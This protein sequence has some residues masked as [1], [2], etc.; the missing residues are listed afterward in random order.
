VAKYRITDPA[1]G[2]TI[3]VSGTAP[4]TQE[5]AAAIFAARKPNLT[6]D[7]LSTPAPVAPPTAMDSLKGAGEAA[8]SLGT[9]LA[10][11]VIS[12]PVA[13]IAALGDIGLRKMAG[14]TEPSPSGEIV[15]KYTLDGYQPKTPEGERMLDFATAPIRALDRGT[16]AA[17]NA[18][19][20]AIIQNVQ[21]VEAERGESLPTGIS[22]IPATAV[23][24][25][26]DLLATAVGMRFPRSPLE[27]LADVRRVERQASDLGVDLTAK[28]DVQTSQLQ[29]AADQMEPASTPSE[30]LEAL[31][32]AIRR[33]RSN[34]S[35]RIGGI[36]DEAEQG[37]AQVP[38]RSA[39]SLQDRLTQATSR[40]ITGD[41][42]SV[43]DL[44][45]ESAGFG[46]AAK[47][48]LSE[49][50]GVRNSAKV[51]VND[52]FAFRAKINS[53][54]PS[55]TNSPEYNALSSMKREVDGFLNETLT[56]DLVSGNPEAIAKWQEAIGQWS[57]FKTA[58]DEN[59]VIRKLQDENATAEQVKNLIFG[60]NV[61]RA[62][63]QAGVV[64]K[65]LKGI[66]G[67]DSPEFQSLRSSALSELLLP[68]VDAEPNFAKFVKNYDAFVRNNP[69]LA[70]EL[71]DT[72][73]LEQMKGL[74]DFAGAIE[75]NAPIETRVR[76]AGF[77]RAAAVLAA[78]HGIAQSSLR[79]SFITRALGAIKP[80][81][82]DARKN[83]MLTE[84]LGYDPRASLFTTEPVRNVAALQEMSE[85]EPRTINDF[86]TQ[87][88]Q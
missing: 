61:V 86:I 34:E 68:V 23:K 79:V 20:D 39:G 51:P 15:E 72:S 9:G 55:D 38:S 65:G 67:E 49:V 24:M 7:P 87:M 40:F 83:K 66:L 70:N 12:A 71:F 42:R 27:R 3:T 4:P 19:Q 59:K 2:E 74:R 54:L 18:T 13:G 26:P 17:A 29:N 8:L 48:S 85:D 11:G 16:T 56:N 57:D 81:A 77:A 73:T 1:T 50:M 32:D 10:A 88:R 53:N 6:R 69:T 5:D 35:K 45:A 14:V 28:N 62:P 25:G 31:P 78:G 75:K 76:N 33:Q 22:A 43:N 58:F 37:G 30:N 36:F 80:N 21:R 82:G 84:L 52:L 47:T 46:N 63:R 64:I 60:M 41:M 44:L